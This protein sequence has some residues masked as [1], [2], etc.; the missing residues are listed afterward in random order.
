[1]V[2]DC[3]VGVRVLPD[4]NRDMNDLIGD[5]VLDVEGEVKMPAV[6]TVFALSRKAVEGVRTGTK[7]VSLSLLLVNAKLIAAVGGGRSSS[8]RD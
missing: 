2:C 8:I 6:D 3:A 5:A 7:F 4:R 1:M